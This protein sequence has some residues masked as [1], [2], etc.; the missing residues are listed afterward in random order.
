[1]STDDPY[2][3]PEA[4]ILTTSEGLSGQYV[5]PTWSNT[6][7]VWWSFYWRAT[8]LGL[9]LGGVT[10][11]VAGGILAVVGRPDLSA[12]AGAILG[13]IVG[14]PVSIWCIKVI[15]GKSFNGFSVR[16]VRHGHSP[17]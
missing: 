2:R 14:I 12:S 16:L 5:E 6:A 15:L 13:Y 10:G 17:D 3:T 11:A 9:L 8:L 1:M 4:A 7:P